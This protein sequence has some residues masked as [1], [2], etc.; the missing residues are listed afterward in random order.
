MR[1]LHAARANSEDCPDR[2]RFL[3][4]VRD[5]VCQ[6]HCANP[7]QK[8]AMSRDSS[9]S[10]VWAT[11]IFYNFFLFNILTTF[12]FLLSCSFCSV[13]LLRKNYMFFISNTA[14]LKYGG[15]AIL[16]T[17]RLNDSFSEQCNFCAISE[18]CR[19]LLSLSPIM[20]VSWSGEVTIRM[21]ASNFQVLFAALPLTLLHGW[22][23]V[24]H[25]DQLFTYPL[26]LSNSRSFW[27]SSLRH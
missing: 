18:Y 11:V 21:K 26:I 13:T 4:S 2:N 15:P 20:V 24:I 3:L 12:S 16:V 22:S 7:C 25:V 17:F 8:E 23:W 9:I 10:E 5:S 6:W 14:Y 27:I 1:S 19:F